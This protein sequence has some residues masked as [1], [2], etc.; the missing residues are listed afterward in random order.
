LSFGFELVLG[1]LLLFTVSLFV[2]LIPGGMKYLQDLST[3]LQNSAWLEDPTNLYKLLLSPPALIVIIFFL[4]VITPV[5][6]EFLKPLG[7]V[8]MWYRRPSKARAFLWGLAGGAGFALSEGLFNSAIN[9][10]AWGA[11]ALMRVG[12]AAMHCIGG[13]L[14][15][16]G[17]YYLIT[18]R[19]PWRFLGAYGASVT[20]HALWNAATVGILLASLFTIIS[21]DNKAVIALAGLLILILVAFILLLTLFMA[22]LILFLTKTLKEKS[23]L[24]GIGGRL[25]D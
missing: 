21:P 16:L 5:V 13:G 22:S 4:V 15:G 23:A 19:R 25:D 7:V 10:R 20:L 18:L 14:V 12:A 2:A 3:N 8:I 1:F 9:L 11:V 17:W 24:G 6:E